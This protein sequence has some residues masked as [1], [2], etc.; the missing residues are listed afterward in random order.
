MTNVITIN[1]RYVIPPAAAIRFAIPFNDGL[2][3]RKKKL[4]ASKTHV[5]ECPQRIMK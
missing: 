5:S 4:T 1:V 3:P 2:I